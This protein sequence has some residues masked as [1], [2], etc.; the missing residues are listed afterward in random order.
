[1][2]A[3]SGEVD[4]EA[5]V[6]IVGAGNSAS[7]AALAAAERGVSVLM[8][9][10]APFDER[11]GNTR[12]TAGSMRVVYDGL[13]DILELV[14][15]LTPSEI[16]TS[17]FGTYPAET[18]MADLA[19]MTEWRT[20]PDLADLVVSR[21]HETLKWMRSKGVRFVPIYHRQAYR[22]DGRFK[23]WGGL[24]IEAAG[25][26]P[27]LVEALAAAT[28]AAGVKTVYDARALRLLADD[29][30]VWGLVAKVKG[31]TCQVRARSVVLAAGGFE[32][33]PEWR[34][35]YLGS[36]WELAKVRGTRF[37]T[38][39]GIRMA[40]EIGAAPY[41][42]WSGAHA[43]SWDRNASEFGDLAIGDHYQKH[44]YPLGIMV[45]AEGRRFVD[46]GADFRNYTYARYGREVLA[47]TAQMAWQ[48]FDARVAHLLRQEYRI[49][50][51]TKV[52]ADSL[53]ELAGK[54]EGV[55]P[56]GFLAMMA[57]YNAAIDQSVDFNP[58]V[59]DGRGTRGVVPAKTNWANPLDTPPFEAYQ[60]TCGVTFTFGG[61][62]VSTG[63]AVLDEELAPIGGLFACGELVGGLFYFNYP[64]GSG[65]TAG[66]VIG[67]AAGGNAADVA[68]TR[69]VAGPSRV[70]GARVDGARG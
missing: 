14:P 40:L 54:L 53:E 37:N 61:L 21:S 23:F 47:Q 29:D 2:A 18:F 70:D 43:V 59:L 28:E 10:R 13:D 49:R 15:D 4:L 65:L 52:T 60:V 6:V 22:I 41:G 44:S 55:D 35:R 20:D 62:R 67:R 58:N 48:I 66:S 30:G 51:I 46:E 33:N 25:G 11:G 17:D 50:Q 38:G 16:E 9:E 63:G 39:D 42:Q 1:M 7:C 34:S 56:E 69:A 36:N 27:G 31:R 57:A 19:R 12:F 45:N 3:R 32:A 68:L 64:G 26:G 24:T 5:D 8:L